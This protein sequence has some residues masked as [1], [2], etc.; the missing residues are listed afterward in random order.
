MSAADVFG[1]VV[2]V[3]IIAYLFYALIRG[4]RL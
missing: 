2:S 4:E 3:L 1:L